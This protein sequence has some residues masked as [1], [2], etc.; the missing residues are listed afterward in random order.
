M[1]RGETLDLLTGYR[2][3]EVLNQGVLATIRPFSGFSSDRDVAS[4]GSV[5]EV[6][7]QQL[8]RDHLHWPVLWIHP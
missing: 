7:I 1:S 5:V 8:R 3:A 2:E 4:R 6:S